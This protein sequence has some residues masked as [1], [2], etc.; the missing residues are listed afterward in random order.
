MNVH[1]SSDKAS[2][3]LDQFPLFLI[4]E[5]LPIASHLRVFFQPEALWFS[6]KQFCGV[7]TVY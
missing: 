7:G 1:E 3:R 2:P 4:E 6:A 5:Q